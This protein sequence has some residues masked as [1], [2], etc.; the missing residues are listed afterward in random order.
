MNSEILN[1]EERKLLIEW[2]PEKP[3]KINIILNSKKDGDTLKIFE[4][5]CKDKSPTLIVILSKDGYKF[6]GY[7]TKQWKKDVKTKDN[8]AFVFSLD[9]KKKYKILKPEQST[10]L[11]D[12]FWLFGYSNNAIV[13]YDNCCNNNNRNYVGNGTYDIKEIGELN[14]GN[15]NF[16]VK[17]F[18]VYH[19][20]Y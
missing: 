6:G 7:T 11:C 14:G 17:N 4:D 8:N 13:I 2:L 3:K 12:F 9:K 15:Q 20:E 1:L 10:Y 19:L 5:K 16:T 18:E